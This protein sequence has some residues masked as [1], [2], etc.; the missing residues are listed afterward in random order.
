MNYRAGFL[1]VVCAWMAILLPSLGAGHASRRHAAGVSCRPKELTALTRSLVEESLATFNKANGE[2]LGTWSPGFP[3]L[4]VHQNAPLIPSKV[5]CGLLFVSQ[6]LEKVLEDQRS[7]LNP[8]DL[9]LHKAIGDTIAHVDMLAKCVKH[10]LR[11]ECSSKP[12]APEMPVHVFERKQWSHSLMS[13]A[14]DYL[15]WLEH[16]LGVHISKD[17]GTSNIKHAV[18]EELCHKHLE[19]SGYLSDLSL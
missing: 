16:R 12:S 1:T 11:G 19:G 9:S 18:S 10:V 8:T 3:E 7:N 17:K 14:R 6:G 15:K 13:T 2:H 4:Q 5:H